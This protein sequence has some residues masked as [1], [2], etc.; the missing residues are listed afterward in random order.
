MGR[1]LFKQ[2]IRLARASHAQTSNLGVP[3][4]LGRGA[5][6]FV[7][8]GKVQPIQRAPQVKCVVGDIKLNVG[9]RCVWQTN[10]NLSELKP[11]CEDYNKY[12]K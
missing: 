6:D 4:G 8:E 5:F 2:E 10:S 11:K 1:T 12:L 7:W 3:A 9:Q